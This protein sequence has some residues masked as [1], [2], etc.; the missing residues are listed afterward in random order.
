MHSKKTC[1]TRTGA[2]AFGELPNHLSFR[3][4]RV[5]RTPEMKSSPLLAHS[6]SWKRDRPMARSLVEAVKAK[7]RSRA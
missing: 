2:D 4:R 3:I 6:L 7:G 5:P 1:P